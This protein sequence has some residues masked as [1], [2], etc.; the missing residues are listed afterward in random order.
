[1]RPK[2]VKIQ[3]LSKNSRIWATQLPTS[4]GPKNNFD[5][6]LEIPWCELFKGMV[7]ESTQKILMGCHNGFPF[8]CLNVFL[9]LVH[10]ICSIFCLNVRKGTL[11]NIET[12]FV[13]FHY[14]C[15]YF[16]LGAGCPWI[17]DGGRAVPILFAAHQFVIMGV[18]VCNVTNLKMDIWLDQWVVWILWQQPSSGTTT[19]PVVRPC[20]VDSSDANGSKMYWGNFKQLCVWNGF[21]TS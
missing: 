15:S 2:S 6:S 8:P 17:G 16:M 9:C 14:G 1:M 10:P 20:T 7:Q 4:R 21:Q 13:S 18:C 11:L 19:I 5:P 3:N 12:I